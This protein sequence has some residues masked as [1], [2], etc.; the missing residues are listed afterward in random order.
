MMRPKSANL[1]VRN[2]RLLDPTTP[3]G[4]ASCADDNVGDSNP[5]LQ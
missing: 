3:N 2:S 5:Y 1:Y 4:G